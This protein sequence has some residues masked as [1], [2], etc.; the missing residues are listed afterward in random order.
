M[1]LEGLVSEPDV[2]VDL[3]VVRQVF[4]VADKLPGVGFGKGF[5]DVEYQAAIR[6]IGNK[7]VLADG[8]LV[9]AYHRALVPVIRVADQCF[10]DRES[11]FGVL[12]G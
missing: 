5:A 8:D 11:G 2:F 4:C 6:V 10:Y 12:A 9:A 7:A 3:A 1:T